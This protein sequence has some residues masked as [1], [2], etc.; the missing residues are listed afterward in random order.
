MTKIKIVLVI[1]IVL[2]MAAFH[3]YSGGIQIF[4]A[5]QQRGIHFGFALALIFL[6]YPYRKYKDGKKPGIFSY[7]IDFVLAGCAIFTGIYIYNNFITLS[8]S[9]NNPSPLLLAIGIFCIVLTLEATRRILGLALPI[10]ALLFVGY[11]LWGHHLPMLFAHS[12]YSLERIITTIGLSSGGILGITLGVSAT[13]VVL[14]IVFGAFLERSGAGKLFIDLAFSLVGKFRGGAAKVAVVASALT[15]S[16]N[17]YAV[18]NVAT[19]GVLTIPLMKKGGYPKHYAGAVESAASTGSM[20]LPPVMGAVAFLLADFLQVEYYKVAL[21]ALIPAILYFV[22]IFIMVDLRAARMG[23]QEQTYEVKDIKEQLK[24][25]GHLLIPLFILLYFLLVKQVSPP[26]A[27]FWGIISVPF[28]CLL[29]KE[30]RMSFK[31]IYEAIDQGIK[32]SLVV[33]AACACA[34]IVIGVIDLTGLGLRF[35]GIMV[36]MSGGNLFLLL[37]LTMFASIIMGMGL[38]PVAS[39]IILAVIAAPAIIRLGV[40]DMAA[41]LFIFYYGILSAITPP[42][43]IAAYTASG[44]AKSEPLK[45]SITAVRLALVAFVIPF[46]FVYGPAL[47]FQGSAVEIV[48]AVITALIGIFAL[49]VSLE[50]YWKKEVKLLSRLFLFLGA[51]SLMSVGI[52]FDI[53]GIVVVGLVLFYE[54][55]QIGK[56][57]VEVDLRKAN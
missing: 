55:K 17:G 49:S 6:L 27:A 12:G 53:V 40:P 39:Y 37:V 35:S 56:G 26:L 2:I 7:S 32:L 38:P 16:V 22:A 45:T 52:V 20:I 10:L 29:R 13:Y 23:D 15:G 41:H 14:F 46:M 48:G 5:L 4:P 9:L 18:S 57:N 19:T 31:A 8:I 36:E 34:G 51:L 44:I 50:G 28:V 33:A 3:L 25:K 47:I 21:A 1:T 42:V 43:A 30:T 24:T 54:W 11:A